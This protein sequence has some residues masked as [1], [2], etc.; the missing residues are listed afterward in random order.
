MLHFRLSSLIVRFY[1]IGNGEDAQFLILFLARCGS[2]VLFIISFTSN[3]KW[4]ETCDT[5]YIFKFKK[6]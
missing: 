6:S 4:F 5:T 3:I 1:R 2:V